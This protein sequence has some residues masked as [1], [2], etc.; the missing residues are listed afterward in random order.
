MTKWQSGPSRFSR[1]TVLS[2]TFFVLHLV[3]QPLSHVATVVYAQV[4]Q[5]LTYQG[6]LTERNGDPFTGT[7][8]VVFRV[9]DAE[10][11]GRKLWEE[12]HAVTLS[13]ADNGIFSIILGSL[14]SLNDLDFNQPLWLSL[15][16]DGEGEMSP[17]QRLTAVGYAMNADTLD[18]LD[19]AQFLRAGTSLVVKPSTDPAENARLIDVQNAAGMTRFNVDLEGDVSVAGN[20]AVSGTITGAS[21]TGG[22]VTSVDSGAGL[23][24][25]PVT[26]S[27]TLAVGAGTGITVNADDIAVKLSSG[28]GLAADTD[29]LSLLRTCSDGQLLKWTAST[30]SWGC[31]ADA[32]AGG[33]GSVTSVDSGAG[34]TGGPVTTSGA[35][36]VGAG[37]GITVNADDVAIKLASGAGLSVDSSGLS[38]LRTCGNGELLKWNTT[39][40]VW[41]CKPDIDTDTDTNSGGTVTS[42]TA[43]TG[44]SGGTITISGMISLSTPVSVANGG[45]GAASLAAGGLLLGQG[46]SAVTTTGVLGKGTLVVGDGALDPALLSVGSDES[47]LVADSAQ[48]A[49]VR[50][51]QGCLPIG[52]ASSSSHNASFQMGVGGGSDTNN[53]LDRVWPVPVAGKVTS[54]RAYVGQAPGSGDSWTVTLR[55]N[56][57]NTALA[58]TISGSSQSCSDAGPVTVS[59]GDRLG[60]TFSEGGSASGTTGSGWSACFVP[61]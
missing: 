10:T 27:G 40:S 1:V 33:T 19:S 29:G 14:T 51:A 45:T 11:S 24:G 30:S 8:T 2:V 61:D 57:S 43:G 21:L 38:V 41:E 54:F 49:G 36:A 22:T 59:A 9:Y 46:I 16:I 47:L 17:R 26:T 31:A 55:K 23:T 13:R 5:L 7:H 60:V 3:T 34:L 15:E 53:R 12:S 35:L 42:I 37:T 18:G 28:A 56:A 58:C 25:G 39:S 50:W 48:A 32:N 4:P 6:R 44:L 20:L 52:G